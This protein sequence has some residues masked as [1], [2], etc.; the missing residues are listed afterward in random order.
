MQVQ[1][2]ISALY[3]SDAAESA[4]ANTFLM[5]FTEQPVWSRQNRQNRHRDIRQLPTIERWPC[6]ATNFSTVQC[7]CSADGSRFKVI[8]YVGVLSVVESPFASR[9]MIHKATKTSLG[10]LISSTCC[11]VFSYSLTF[12]DSTPV[13]Q[14]STVS[15]RRISLGKVC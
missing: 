7:S 6:D 14:Y 15:K 11:F 13:Q 12:T 8:C 9:Q 4:R 1:A 3:G 5:E 10:S 2:A